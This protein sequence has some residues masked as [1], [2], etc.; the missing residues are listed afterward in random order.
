MNK[1]VEEA[2]KIAKHD[3]LVNLT[4]TALPQPPKPLKPKKQTTNDVP[5]P[6]YTKRVSESDLPQTQVTKPPKSKENASNNDEF[7]IDFNNSYDNALLSSIPIELLSSQAASSEVD[8]KFDPELKLSQIVPSQAAP[9]LKAT[10]SSNEK[11]FFKNR[12]NPVTPD[13]PLSMTQK[14]RK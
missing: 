5:I 1:V 11:K 2:D 4:S 13:V 6:L 10:Q 9:T 3:R 8:I 7:A 12:I 14:L